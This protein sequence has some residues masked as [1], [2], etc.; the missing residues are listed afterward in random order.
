MNTA[1]VILAAGFSRRMQ[2]AD[3]L[4]LNIDGVP[5][6]RHVISL[7]CTCGLFA[8]VIVV[9]NQPDIAAFATQSGAQAVE[10]PLAAQGMGTSV[11]AGTRALPENTDF[12]AFLTADQ[13]FLTEDILHRLVQT[14]CGQNKIAVPRVDGA[15]KSPCIFPARYFGQCKALSADRG[16]KGIYQQHLDEVVWVDFPDGRAWRDIDT[17]TDY[18]AVISGCAPA[19]QVTAQEMP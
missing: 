13:P 2:H 3:K 5:M 15:P 12:C 1:A 9:T 11:A 17:Q 8:I 4:K 19:K 10:N 6:Y 18:S 7:A 16:G 14:A